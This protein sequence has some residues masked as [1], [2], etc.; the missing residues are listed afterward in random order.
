MSQF[1][2]LML[3]VPMFAGKK[4]AQPIGLGDAVKRV[5]T[6]VGIRTCGGCQRRA[7]ALNRMLVFTPPSTPAKK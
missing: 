3:R 2:P 7:Q 4:M 6:A 1:K 5:T